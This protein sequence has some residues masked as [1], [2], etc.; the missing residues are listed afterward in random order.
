MPM[1]HLKTAASLALSMALVA[2]LTTPAAGAETRPIKALLV[3]GGC[4]H[5]YAQQKD[6]LKLGLEARAFVQVDI[7]YVKD[8]STRPKLPIYGNP[9]YAKGYDVVIHD[10]CSADVNDPEVI[11]G[12]LQPHR[13][14][15]PGV[16]LHCAM[17]CYRFGDFGKPV[18]AGAP[19]ARWYEY[20][21][22]HSSGHG[23]QKPIAIKFLDPANWVIK[24]MADWTTI[25]E[26]LYNNIEVAGDTTRLATGTQEGEAKA[27]VVVWSH[28]Y[29]DKKTRVFS[30]TIGHNNETVSDPRYLDL[31]TRGLLWAVNRPD[32]LKN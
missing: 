5:D 9:N 24:G 16:N 27:P 31:V 23:A 2:I 19:N 13:D 10:E 4:C 18:I 14:G 7:V 11:Q 30:T 28:L 8:D 17:H 6:V 21:G 3:A 12:V 32:V 15:V 25:N 1:I 29:G 20:L 22:L 26:E